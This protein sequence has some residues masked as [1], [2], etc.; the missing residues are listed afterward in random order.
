MNTSMIEVTEEQHDHSVGDGSSSDRSN[1]RLNQMKLLAQKLVEDSE[2][3]EDQ[4]SDK[5]LNEDEDT[6][7]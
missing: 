3:Q 2:M 4:E 1:I 7:P 6:S 5:E